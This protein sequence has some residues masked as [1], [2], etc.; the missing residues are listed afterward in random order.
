LPFNECWFE[1]AQADRRF[2]ASAPFEPGD[3]KVSRVGFLCTLLNHQGSWSAQLFWSFAAS[4]TF[5]GHLL[6]P[7]LSGYMLIVDPHQSDV[8][9]A[10]SF[11]EASGLQPFYRQLSS[12][13]DWIGESGFLIATLALLNWR[14]TAEVQP[15]KAAN[16]RRRLLG[17][18]LLFDYSLIS[19]PHRY[20]QRHHLNDSTNPTQFRQHWCK[21]HFKARKTGIFWWSDHLRGDP[22]HGFAH[23]DYKLRLPEEVVA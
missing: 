23:R 22:K 12:M 6:P 17:K 14:N 4:E 13:D 2:F 15:V 8:L 10:T 3:G 20:Q 21:G 11:D 1:V 9:E 19:I 16:K 5:I 7:S 18:P